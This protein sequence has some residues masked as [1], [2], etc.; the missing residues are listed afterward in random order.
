MKILH[1][2]DW[3]LGH[4]LCGRRRHEE[5]EA[6]LRLLPAVLSAE[7]VDALLIAGDI[8]DGV[9]PGVRTQE[10]Y[11]RF[12]CSVAGSGC[13]HV[14]IIAGNHD[15]PSFLTAPRDLLR[16]LHIHVFGAATGGPEEEVLTLRDARGAPECVVCA[17]P[18]LRDRD[19]RVAEPGE[20]QADKEAKL[21]RGIRGRYARVAALA[22]EARAAS[23]NPA[24]PVLGMGH[25]FAAGGISVEGDGVRDL[26]L[27]GLVRVEASAFPPAMDYVALG[28]LHKPQRVGGSDRIRYCGSPLP[29]SFGEAREEKSLCLVTFAG[30]QATARALPLPEFRR[31]ESIRGDWTAIAGRLS[32]LAAEGADA[33]LEILYEGEDLLPD[34]GQDLRK[35]V[36]NTGLEILR[37]RNARLMARVLGRDREEEGP[38]ALDVDEVFERCLAAHGI[39]ED[40]RYELRRAHGEILADLRSEEAE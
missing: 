40:Q 17:V 6:F 34:L 7:G 37:V 21:L 14:V 11:Y 2:S 31:L 39:P 8:F 33:W 5:H 32:A 10:I 15:S 24:L 18:F 29:L 20:S 38:D 22:E 1:T 12:L 19:I 23:G 4:S 27:G 26:Y 16:N 13:R 28:H 35:A 25:L 9:S 30:R 3:H 36:R